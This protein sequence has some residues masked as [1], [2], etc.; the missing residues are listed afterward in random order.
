MGKFKQKH[1]GRAKSESKKG[2][3]ILKLLAKEK[4]TRGEIESKT[5]ITRSGVH[6]FIK[7]LQ[8]RKLVRLSKKLKTPKGRRNPAEAFKLNLVNP[9]AVQEI[10][11]M[12]GL[13]LEIKT[14]K[15]GRERKIGILKAL[16][17]GPL[18]MRQLK[19]RFGLSERHLYKLLNNLTTKGFVEHSGKRVT[20]D[21]SDRK[22][23]TFQIVPSALLKLK[24]IYP[25]LIVER[26]KEEIE[27]ENVSIKK[28]VDEKTISKHSGMGDF[29]ERMK[30][31]KKKKGK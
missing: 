7:N 6:Y 26:K 12:T 5:D 24:E 4:L 19:R 27:K 31:L 23:K 29:L 21:I 9:T 10:N 2:I 22:A 3:N 13:K 16:V 1:R 20:D 11:E 14:P 18:T 30:N 8:K 25:E 15:M 28:P 17:M